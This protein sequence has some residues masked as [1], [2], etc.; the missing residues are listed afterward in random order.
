MVTASNPIYAKTDSTAKGSIL[1]RH[2][3]IQGRILLGVGI[4]LGLVAVVKFS[5]IG[6]YP[7]EVLPYGI[8]AALGV[9]LMWAGNRFGRASSGRS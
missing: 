9:S 1:V 7:D 6:Y 5:I 2:L 3:S 4:I 8:V